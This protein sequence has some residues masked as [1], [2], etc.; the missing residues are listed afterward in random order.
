MGNRNSKQDWKSLSTE[1]FLDYLNEEYHK[2]H[3]EYEDYFWISYMGDHSVDK[4]KDEAMAR[5]DAF[6]SDSEYLKKIE[7]STKIVDLKT[8][9]RLLAWKRFF[10]CYHVSKEA[11]SLKNK[12]IHLE[13][14]ID[15]KRSS[16]KEGYTDP[17]TK[18]F[19]EASE[20][21]M[22]YMMVVE[23]DEKIRKACFVAREKLANGCVGEYVNLVRLRNEYA[24]KIGYRDFY[25]YKVRHEDGMTKKELFGIF[26]SIYR[27]TKYAK[28]DIRILEKTMPGLRKPWNF[29]YMMAGDFTKE[30]DPY[31]QFQEALIR[32]GGGLSPH[33][34]LILKKEFLILICLTEKENGTTGSVIG[35]DW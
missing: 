10:D 30:E 5:R 18:K 4:K 27:K 19:R 7:E 14:K 22:R 12:I 28:K 33:W 26:D 9:S 29:S 3:S 13:S 1:D 16:R 6:R 17:Y 21:K 8:K 31:F 23:K 25:D 11:L 24:R 20:L 35:P 34:A 15:Q 32:W 2:L